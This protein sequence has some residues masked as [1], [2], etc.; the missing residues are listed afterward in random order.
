[1]HLAERGYA[2]AVLTGV[3]A[4]AGTWSN[5]P[6]FASLWHW[7]AALVLLGLALEGVLVRRTIIHADIETSTRALLG[8]EQ[9]AVYAFRNDSRRNVKIQFATAAPA[10]LQAVEQVRV[11]EAPRGGSGRDS[12]SL[13]PVRL[14]APPWPPIP[15]RILGRFGLAWWGRSLEPGRVVP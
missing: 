15:A 1:M 8:R 14:G 10:G 11:V 4:I 2:L 3:L 7:P 6:A 13:L 5:E 9:A 12:V